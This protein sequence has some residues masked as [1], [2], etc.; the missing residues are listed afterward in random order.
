LAASNVPDW[1]WLSLCV[2]LMKKIY[3]IDNYDRNL[4]ST[5]EFV[6][7]IWIR[8]S[9]DWRYMTLNDLQ[10]LHEAI[11]AAYEQDVALWDWPELAINSWVLTWNKSSHVK[12]EFDALPSGHIS[13]AISWQLTHSTYGASY[14]Q[15]SYYLAGFSKIYWWMGSVN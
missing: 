15:Y 11:H 4:L 14:W 2:L 5:C 10:K 3:I 9:T 12:Y 1:G 13:I 7:E 8:P 6:R